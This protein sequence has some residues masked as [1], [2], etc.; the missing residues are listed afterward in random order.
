MRR[1]KFPGKL[2]TSGCLAHWKRLRQFGIGCTKDPACIPLS[3]ALVVAIIA[4][5]QPGN[6]VVTAAIVVLVVVVVVVGVAVV[7]TYSS[8]SNGRVLQATSRTRSARQFE[9]NTD[10][11][12][13]APG[14]QPEAGL[15]AN[16]GD[17]KSDTEPR[18][19][20]RRAVSLRRGC[21]LR[22]G[23]P[24]NELSHHRLAHTSPYPR[25]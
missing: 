14:C 6:V 2:D 5:W 25:D 9:K 7:A 21:G 10:T 17:K 4:G 8:S 19:G 3:M 15:R 18:R 24:A 12:E 16:S 23:S 11:A 22:W 13:R 1:C 20:V